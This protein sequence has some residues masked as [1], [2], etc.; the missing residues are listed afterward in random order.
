MNELIDTQPA[1]CEPPYKRKPWTP[2][3]ITP[4]GRELR[5]A[6]TTR[7]AAIHLS[8]AQQTLRKWAMNGEG[9]VKPVR[10]RGRLMWSVA[11]LKAALGVSA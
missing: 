9:P 4:L 11:D 3:E 7:E 2:P 6:I 10:V 8:R 5:T 1:T